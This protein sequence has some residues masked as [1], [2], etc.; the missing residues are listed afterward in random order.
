MSTGGPRAATLFQAMFGV[1]V[2][3]L[4]P[5][6]AS[7][8]ASA[9]SFADYPTWDEVVVAQRNESKAKALQQQLQASLTN[10]QTEAERTQA[11]ADAMGQIYFEAQQAYDE[12]LI[13]TEAL[14]EQTEEAEVDAETAYRAAAL[15]IAEMSKTGMIDT[16]AQ[17]FT[18]PGSPD[19]LIGRLSTSRI[20]SERYASIYERAIELR[21]S[22][23]ALAEQEE[24]AQS[25][26]EVLRRDAEAAFEEAQVVAAAAGAALA[27]AEQDI[28]EIRARIE[29]LQGIREQT[30]A[31][32][33]QGLR[34]LWGDAAEGEISQTGWSR[35]HPGYI[36]SNFGSRINPVTGVRQLHTGVDMAGTGCGGTIR[37]A[38]AGVVTYAGWNGSWGYYVAI[39]HQDGTGSGYA[40]IQAGGIGVQIGQTVSPGQP[41]A[42]VGTTGQSTGCHLH[43]IV[44]VNGNRDL[45][46]PVPFMREQGV[47]LG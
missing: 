16:T 32:Y 12:Q 21:N 47:P 24:I 19:A 6:L 30:V 9:A 39:D 46:D 10:L 3:S 40:H 36:T 15:I 29:Y 25:L 27:R 42:K 38:K 31:D 5:V 35:P 14:I 11:E 37:A 13:V 45:V 43:F 23:N 18:M 17:L 20:L 28:A 22:A 26:L 1:V 41:I 4:A 7:S 2:L 34:D 8:P 33:N 44:R